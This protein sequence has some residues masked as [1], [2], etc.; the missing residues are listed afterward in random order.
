MTTKNNYKSPLRYPGGKA[1]MV[2]KILE[3]A[4]AGYQEY[5]EPF[6][7]GGSVLFAVRSEDMNRYCQV[8]DIFS[9]LMTFWWQCKFHSSYMIKTINDWKQ[10]YPDGRELHKNCKKQVTLAKDRGTAFFILNRI[11]FSGLT[12]SGGYSKASYEGRFNQSHISRI[13][14]AD[15]VLE[16]VELR[17][18]GYEAL[19]HEPGKD[20]WLFMDPPYD[21]KSDNLYGNK[22]NTHKGFD[23][24]KFADECKKS[25]HKWLITY[26][27]NENIRKL[28]SW[29][30]IQEIDVTYNMN[31]NNK[32]KKE[33]FITN[34]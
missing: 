4:P 23:H 10:Q 1:R 27:D 24:V 2:K 6:L 15:S 13:K 12:M 22:G 8:S 30:N 16:N 31:S 9:E 34:Y 17:F 5:R 14:D 11:S 3:R 25:P 28:F 21:I 19:L 32:K 18:V 7:G 26:N 33:L 20:V 29:A